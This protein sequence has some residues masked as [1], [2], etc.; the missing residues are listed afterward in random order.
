M[1]KPP[2]LNP[3]EITKLFDYVASKRHGKR[4]RLMLLLSFEGMSISEIANVKIGNVLAADGSI[5]SALALS[6]DRNSRTIPLNDHVR[7]EMRS[8]LEYR[9]PSMDLRVIAS[10]SLMEM[11]LF[12]TAKSLG[13]SANTACHH[14]FMLYREA[15][16]KGSSES[17]V[18]TF[19]MI[20]LLS[21]SFLETE[22]SYHHQ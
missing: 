16:V 13:F 11:P 9:F 14:V 18:A 5:K 3:S 1:P 4:D 2:P 22:G 6:K 19:R 8:L 17:G 7:E 12:T 20:G 21:I 15:G 10:S